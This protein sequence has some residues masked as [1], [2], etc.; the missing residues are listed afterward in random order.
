VFTT[1]GT[2]PISGFGRAKDR[3][4]F[5]MDVAAE[6][7]L[8][9]L[10]RTVASGMARLGVAP[11]V[12]EKVLNHVS[13][14]ISG[15]AAVYNRHGYQTEKREALS[16]WAA[17]LENLMPKLQGKSTRT[18]GHPSRNGSN[19]LPVLPYETPQTSLAITTLA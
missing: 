2:S 3:L 1:T 15:V 6:W 7:R 4:D 14:Q 11:H 16:Q 8:H 5:V 9:D 13:G 12:I 17:H 19:L 18:S 10:R